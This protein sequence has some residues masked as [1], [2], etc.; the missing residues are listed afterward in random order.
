MPD[1][2]L[3]QK[4]LVWSHKVKKTL[5][6]SSVR[7]AT[8]PTSSLKLVYSYND[9]FICVSHNYSETICADERVGYVYC[10]N[11]TYVATSS[12]EIF[13]HSPIKS[14]IQ[15]LL[16]RIQAYAYCG[17]YFVEP[18]QIYNCANVELQING[19]AGKQFGP[20]PSSTILSSALLNGPIA[21][22]SATLSS[23]P[24]SIPSDV[25][26]FSPRQTSSLVPASTAFITSTLVVTSCS[27]GTNNCPATTIL[28]SSAV[29]TS[30]WACGYSGCVIPPSS[31]PPVI[32]LA[33]DMPLSTE[34]PPGACDIPSYISAPTEYTAPD[35]TPEPTGPSTSA[36]SNTLSANTAST[37]PSAA[38][39]SN[40]APTPAA[41]GVP[42]S[43]SVPVSASVSS[44]ISA[45]G[46]ATTQS[47]T[48]I[49]STVLVTRTSTITSC[50]PTIT[51]CPADYSTEVP[52]TTST[53][54]TVLSCHGGCMDG[55]V[56][57]GECVVRTRVRVSTKGEL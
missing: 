20:A 9:G 51:A 16:S 3:V 7:R 21:P 38:G 40:S 35:E 42:V 11:Y 33:S 8:Q 26:V 50:P 10:S 4:A 22:P 43:G 45:S 46:A 18:E 24:L 44:P 55:P 37:P 57:V 19:G 54:T 39:D 36:S 34:C 30:T 13:I 48:T 14:D 29:V 12:P 47:T 23:I 52:Y 5:I 32:E 28:T 15:L 49:L 6:R 53:V 1:K 27:D 41:T 56:K 25:P 2:L 31:L 17:C